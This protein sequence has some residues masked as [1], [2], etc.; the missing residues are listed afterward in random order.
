MR[1]VRRN[2]IYLLIHTAGEKASVDSQHMAGHEAGT[3]RSQENGS[4]YQFAQLA[5]ALHGSA[6]KKLLSALGA[7]QQL[8]IELRAKHSW[9]DGIHADTM[10]GPFNG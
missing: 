5:K 1:T 10:A 8:R 7:I 6:Q 4:A 2:L 9:S 3:L